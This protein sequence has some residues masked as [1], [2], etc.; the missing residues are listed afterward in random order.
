[1]APESKEGHH[2]GSPPVRLEEPRTRGS[3]IHWARL[4]DL[5]TSIFGMG[6]RSPIRRLIVDRAEP[7]PGE[8]VLDVGCGTGTLA[9]PAKERVG[10]SGE[11]QGID[12]SPEM[13]GVAREK[14]VK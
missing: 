9:F 3:V 6:S 12:P 10:A 14:A 13:I 1:M 7:R 2:A 5:F 8:R 4:Y 11:V